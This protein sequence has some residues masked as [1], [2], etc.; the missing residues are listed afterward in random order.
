[1]SGTSVFSCLKI[2]GRP[3]CKG[4]SASA[5]G[6]GVEEEKRQRS[7]TRTSDSIPTCPL[8]VSLIHQLS[9][10]ATNSTSSFDIPCRRV[11]DL[12]LRR[13]ETSEG[14]VVGKG[15]GIHTPGSPGFN[16]T[17]SAIPT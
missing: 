7:L 17:Q 5:R 8:A 13:S 4:E 3:M 16:E 11:S 12:E 15:K 9:H 2:P 6:W 14:H 10:L 1:M